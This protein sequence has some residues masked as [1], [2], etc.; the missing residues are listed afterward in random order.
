MGSFDTIK[1]IIYYII[2]FFHTFNMCYRFKVID[3]DVFDITLL[4]IAINT[5]KFFKCCL[6]I[7][8]FNT[9]PRYTIIIII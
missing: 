8:Y 3:N 1:Y 7:N 9:F 6:V 4:S 2:V 5:F